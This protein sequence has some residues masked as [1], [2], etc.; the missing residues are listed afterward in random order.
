MSAHFAESPL[1]IKINGSLILLPDAQPNT[2]T[3]SLPGLAKCCLHKFFSNALAQMFLCCINSSYL[4]W[5]GSVNCFVFA[6]HYELR[7]PD[8]YV[9]RFNDQENIVRLRKLIEL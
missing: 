8:G 3:A 7:V 1:L 5:L 4:E 9:F 2:I 6:I